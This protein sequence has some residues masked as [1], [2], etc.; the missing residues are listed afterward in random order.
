MDTSDGSLAILPPQTLGPD[1]KGSVGH[2]ERKE[3]GTDLW[4]TLRVSR[5]SGDDLLESLETVVNGR[6][7]QG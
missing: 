2:L 1:K 3:E 7:I 6:L 4:E 5:V